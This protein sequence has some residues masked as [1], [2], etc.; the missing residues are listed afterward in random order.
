MFDPTFQFCNDIFCP[1]L[2]SDHK[3]GKPGYLLFLTLKYYCNL[4]QLWPIGGHWLRVS[5]QIASRFFN[6]CFEKRKKSFQ[7]QYLKYIVFLYLSTAVAYPRAVDFK[8]IHQ[9]TIDCFRVE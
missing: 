2:D 6:I 3:D 1:T 8:Q 9:L 5:F 7:H 4:H